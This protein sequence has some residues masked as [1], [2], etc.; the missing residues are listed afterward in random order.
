MDSSARRE[1]RMFI[2]NLRIDNGGIT[3]DDVEFLKQTRPHLLKS[4]NALRQQLG[5]STKMYV[6]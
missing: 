5:A 1:A 4:I 6:L 2:D 3:P